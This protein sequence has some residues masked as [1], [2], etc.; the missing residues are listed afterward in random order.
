MEMELKCSKVIYC[1]RGIQ[2][3]RLPLDFDKLRICV[4]TIDGSLQN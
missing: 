4:T 3:Y 1:I 2:I